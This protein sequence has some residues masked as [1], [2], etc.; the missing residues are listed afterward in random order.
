MW[1]VQ[2]IYLY[3]VLHCVR[4]TNTYHDWFTAFICSIFHYFIHLPFSLVR[5]R[6][7]INFSVLQGPV[8][9]RPISA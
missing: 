3:L 8:V 6:G 7:N 4:M 1:E 9:R 2:M 5:R